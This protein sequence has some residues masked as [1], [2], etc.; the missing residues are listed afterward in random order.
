MAHLP[1]PMVFSKSILSLLISSLVFLSDVGSANPP[2]SIC[3]TSTSYTNGS[4]FQ[5]NLNNV[6][7]SLPI[8]ASISDSYIVS[9]G[10]DPDKV[11]SLYMCL[12]YI[13]SESCQICIDTAREDI[14]KLCPLSEEAVVW[15]EECQLWYSSRNFYGVANVTGNIGKDNIQNISEPEKFESALNEV[16]YN[17]T[18]VAAFSP[19][20][21]MYAA[22]EAP[23]EN[24]TIY[25]LVMCTGDLSASN[26]STCL[27][28][29]IRDKAGCCYAAI[30]ARIL[31]RNCYLRY[32]FYHF[33]EGTTGSIDTS[34]R[35][36]K[37]KNVA[38]KIWMITGLIAL[39]ALAMI[40]CCCICCVMK[41]R[42]RESGSRTFS[43]LIELHNLSQL[44]DSVFHYQSFNMRSD[45]R[46]KEIP[47]IAL[48][49][50]RA[51]TGN[52]S[53]S[54]KLG[55]GG[56]GPVYKAWNL[57]NEGK[58][59][60]LMDPLLADSCCQDQFLTDMNIRLL[61]VQE[62][63]Y[64]R[65]TM[66]SVVLMLKSESATHAQPKRPPFSLRKLNENGSNG[67]DYAQHSVNGLTI[68]QILP[69]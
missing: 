26:C 2:Y 40:F 16:L 17:I 4:L 3:S 47:Y 67:P 15:E 18:E 20:A 10:N 68:S 25:A 1:I 23:F 51:A 66:S 58:G 42:N 30:G 9:Y 14:V 6:L 8:H 22:G 19:S 7:A 13:T 46:S 45:W 21:N 5:K 60:D 44:V 57:W 52:F 35:N 43:H 69:R 12:N 50:L 24:K 38:R 32:E 61:C 63:A 36:T 54:N 41:N 33:Y 11:Y 59:L 62:D 48:S 37:G 39:T 29:A 55:Q 28:S 65:P 53:D 56:F 49:S 34:S 64:D 31:S 27:K